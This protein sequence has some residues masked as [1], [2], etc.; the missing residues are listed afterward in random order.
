MQFQS[1]HA[2]MYSNQRLTRSSQRG[3]KLGR[4]Y[5]PF[6]RSLSKEQLITVISS[7]SIGGNLDARAYRLGFYFGYTQE[8]CNEEKSDKYLSLYNEQEIVKMSLFSEINNEVE[9][10]FQQFPFAPIA[11]LVE[12]H[13]VFC[14]TDIRTFTDK[15]KREHWALVCLLDKE[16]Q[17]Q[18]EHVGGKVTVTLSKGIV[19]KRDVQMSKLQT[20]L[21]QNKGPFHSLSID[22]ADTQSGQPYRFL[23]ELSGTEC[24]CVSISVTTPDDFD[25]FLDSDDLP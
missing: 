1:I 11:T 2:W 9:S 8:M 13:S 10:Q 16:T 24:P 21:M 6:H 20:A 14:L 18:V 4:L 3:F 23:V 12:M 22:E 5:Y 15:K 7:L 19:Q 25:P 17:S